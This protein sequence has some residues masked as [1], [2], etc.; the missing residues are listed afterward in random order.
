M[1]QDARAELGERGF[2]AVTVSGGCMRPA[3]APGQTV[4][5]RRRPPRTG[6][7]ALLEASGALEIHRL[8]DRI[9]VA[10]RSWYVHGG[11]AG[12]RRGVAR[13][14]EVLGVV[15]VPAPRPRTSGGAL[16]LALRGGA[17]FCALG[18]PPGALTKIL[19]A[20][21]GVF[22]MTK[23]EDDVHAPQ[24]RMLPHSLEARQDA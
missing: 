4:I 13:A 11:D 17:V 7:V 15:P 16:G 23:V 1:S 3:L 8:V 10:G 12:D 9:A 6:D 20:L 18:L 2:L 5:V 22:K 21:R 14:E 24:D 19:W